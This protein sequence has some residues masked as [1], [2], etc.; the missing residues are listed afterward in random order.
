MS[1]KRLVLKFLAATSDQPIIYQLVKKYDLMINILKA[2]INPQKEGMMIVEING[3]PEDY[4]KGLAYLSSVGVTIQPLS[5]D[6]VRV[7]EKCTQCGACSNFCPTSALYMERPSMEVKFDDE[8]CVAC[9]LCVKACPSRA[10]EV[11]F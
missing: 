5:Q 11:H 10:M 3:Q 6:V 8:K 2:V 7:E 9:L 1:P 4:E